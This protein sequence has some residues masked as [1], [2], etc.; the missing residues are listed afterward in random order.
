MGT[1]SNELI[2]AH[3][4]HGRRDDASD[5]PGNFPANYVGHFLGAFGVAGDAAHLRPAAA[6]ERAGEDG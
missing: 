6:P 1:L 4:G 5:F 2:S 3:R